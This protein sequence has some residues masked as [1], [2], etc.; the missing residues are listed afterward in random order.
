[1]P[2]K[3]ETAD[4]AAAT[5]GNDAKA[6]PRG[7]QIVWDDSEM[8]TLFANVVNA[9]STVEE[10]TLFFGTNQSWNLAAGDDIHV[11]LQQRVV[12]SPHAAKRLSVLLDSVLR[13]YEKRFG[14]LD[15]EGRLAQPSAAIADS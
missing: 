6:A 14:K 1:M 4:K 13:E 15:A 5:K 10:F 8:Q 7:V 2:D 12:L 3:K 11:K 9:S